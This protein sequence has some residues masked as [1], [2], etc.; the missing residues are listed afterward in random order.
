MTSLL[1]SWKTIYVKRLVLSWKRNVLA[2]KDEEDVLMYCR[3]YPT[4]KIIVATKL[5]HKFSLDFAKPITKLP[6]LEFQRSML[7]VQH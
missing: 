6:D 5:V 7:Q 4:V 3:A 1:I 2:I